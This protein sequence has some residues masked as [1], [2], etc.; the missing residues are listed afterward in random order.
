MTIS[1]EEVDLT[2]GCTQHAAHLK[3][4]LIGSNKKRPF[5]KGAR[6][7]DPCLRYSTEDFTAVQLA[8]DDHS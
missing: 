2:G 8:S 5:L 7:E 3:Q 4:G 6:G 1:I